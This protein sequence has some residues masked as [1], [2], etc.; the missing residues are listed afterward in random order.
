MFFRLT[1]M[2]VAVI[3]AIIGLSFALP[4][5]VDEQ[6]VFGNVL[7]AAGY[8]ILIISAQRTL[9]SDVE[10]AEQAQASTQNMQRQIDNLQ[11]ILAEM[12]ELPE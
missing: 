9:L 6:N 3:A 10:K 11:K 4:L 1:P 2:A 8:V 5:T 12:P 7:L